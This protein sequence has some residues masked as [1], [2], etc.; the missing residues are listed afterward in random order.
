MAL[1]MQ[2]HAVNGPTTDGHLPEF[3]WARASKGVPGG[4]DLV[5]EGMPSRFNFKFE[6]MSADPVV[7]MEMSRDVAAA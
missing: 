1:R 3:Q 6:E 7:V 2:A 5:H 4:E